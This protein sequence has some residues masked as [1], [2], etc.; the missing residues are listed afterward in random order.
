MTFGGRDPARELHARRAAWVRERTLE[1]VDRR[2]S[3][4]L[5]PLGD[6]ELKSTI[7]MLWELAGKY[8]K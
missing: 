6:I 4:G 7:N 3:M 2:K 8:V 1:D 5:P